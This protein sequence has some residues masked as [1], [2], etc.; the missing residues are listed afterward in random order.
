M[1]AKKMML[2]NKFM[3]KLIA[4]ENVSFWVNSV[5][6]KN[7]V[8]NKPF[9]TR[10]HRIL[11]LHFRTPVTLQTGT[12]TSSE[13]PGACIFFNAKAEQNFR[14]TTK[15]LVL[16]GI[17]MPG[18]F[19]TLIDEKHL[20][21]NKV[22]YPSTT[23]FIPFQIDQI[24]RAAVNESSYSDDIVHH[25]TSI[26]IIQLARQTVQDTNIQQKENQELR[27][28]C[29]QIVLQMLNNP[30][31]CWTVEEMA[32]MANLSRSRFSTMF[33]SL[34]GMTPKDC[35]IELRLKHAIILL[36]NTSMNI[37]EISEQC[38]FKSPYYFS[39][40]FHKRIGC[41]PS[42]YNDRFIIAE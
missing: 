19:S 20:P 39:R 32:E 7:F 5:F 15:E 33:K 42:D 28:L 37:S 36:T 40:L 23:D 41:S 13:S 29:R 24:Q 30:A 35:L 10:D 6:P 4:H 11:F 27:S 31:Y 17:L 1:S 38:G 26:L 2:A 22:F 3:D 25:L 12:S 18:N 9:G 16:D 8:V 21:L 34:L 14:A